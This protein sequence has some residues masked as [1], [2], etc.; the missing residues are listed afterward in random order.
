MSPELGVLS[1][2]SEMSSSK[3]YTTPTFQ[4]ESPQKEEVGA[5]QITFVSRVTQSHWVHTI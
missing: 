4:P 5:P 1:M 2:K 3:P